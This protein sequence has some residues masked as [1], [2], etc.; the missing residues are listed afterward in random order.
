MS[1]G[2]LVLIG[3]GV[4]F[5]VLAVFTLKK[6]K[7]VVPPTHEE[8][9]TPRLSFDPS[10]KEPEPTPIPQEPEVIP[11]PPTVEPIHK[12]CWGHRVSVSDSIETICQSQEEITVYTCVESILDA[13]QLY[14]SEEACKFERPNWSLNYNHVKSSGKY[15]SV[16]FEGRVLGFLDC[17]E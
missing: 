4:L 6:K 2:I 1:T 16:D 7:N 15:C 10:I 5:G 8:T 3:I 11:V 17:I 13:Q 9:P 14:M 12:L